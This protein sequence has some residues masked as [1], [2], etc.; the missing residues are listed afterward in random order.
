[1][2]KD[3][4]KQRVIDHF[5]STATAFTVHVSKP[6]PIIFL[7]V[8]DWYSYGYIFLLWFANVMFPPFQSY[9]YAFFIWENNSLRTV[10]LGQSYTS[11]YHLPEKPD[12]ASF[13]SKR[14]T[15]SQPWHPNKYIINNNNT[16]RAFWGGI[17]Q[18]KVYIT[19]VSTNG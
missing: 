3:Q 16:F 11:N 5:L 17:G 9:W 4:L 7:S 19:T 1:M 6:W 14:L 13:V 15:F 8:F 18:W 2:R 10:V 12:K